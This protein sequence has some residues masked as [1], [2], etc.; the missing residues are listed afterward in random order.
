M[1]MVAVALVSLL[2]FAMIGKTMLEGFIERSFVFFPAKPV[3]FTPREWGMPFEDVY[4]RTPDNLT[5]NAWLIRASADSPMVMWFH[6]NAGNIADR[7]DNARL[8][9]DRGLSLFM[10][11]Y[12]GYGKSEGRPSEKG[13]Y[14]DGHAAYE[15]IVSQAGVAPDGLIV[16]G[17]SLGSCV[18]V[19]VASK[20]PCAGVILESAFTNMAD[21]ARATLPLPGLGIFKDKFDCLGRISSV[22][23]PILFFHGDKDEIVPYK[24]GRELFEAARG[25]KDF[26]TIKGAHHNDTYIVGRKEYFDR[27]EQFCRGKTGKARAVTG[28][29]T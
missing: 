18:A 24:F 21:M 2:G 9:F 6:G 16:F 23:T 17:R 8:L 28:E 26:Y 7:L 4:F 15:H 5:L 14:L 1:V 10:V 29:R 11:D 12:R 3:P 25:D 20:N 13:I 19:R 22:S 27:F